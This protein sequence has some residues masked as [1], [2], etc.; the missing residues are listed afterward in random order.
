M[1]ELL[2]SERGMTKPQEPIAVTGVM[3]F[4]ALNPSCALASMSAWAALWFLKL[5]QAEK[6]VR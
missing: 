3:G 2:S 5:E 6:V 1:D 4:A